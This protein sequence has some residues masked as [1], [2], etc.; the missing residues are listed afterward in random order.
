MVVKH[1]C[2][3]S[4]GNI[5][6]RSREGGTHFHKSRR[7]ARRLQ[8]ARTIRPRRSGRAKR[9]DLTAIYDCARFTSHDP[10]EPT[11]T[12]SRNRKNDKILN[13]IKKKKR[14]RKA[15][16]RKFKLSGDRNSKSKHLPCQRHG[17]HAVREQTR[18]VQT[19]Q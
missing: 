19:E 14:K 5:K 15:E 12:E 9:A 4:K 6:S 10:R 7:V 16:I 18:S 11:E 1:L 2:T 8:H 13:G 3:V 17:F